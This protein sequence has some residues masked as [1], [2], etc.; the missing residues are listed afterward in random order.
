MAYSLMARLQQRFGE[1]VDR[2]TRREFLRQSLVAGTAMLLSGGRVLAEPA[3]PAGKS[4]IVIGAG[5]AGLAA[6]YELGSVGYDVTVIEARNRIGG[7]VVTFD[8]FVPG[9]FVEGGGELIGRNHPVWIAY[10]KKFGL[11]FIEIPDTADTMP[12]VLDGKLLPEK[13]ASRL[14]DEMGRLSRMMDRDAEPVVA[15]RPWQ[16]PHARILDRRSVADWLNGRHASTLAKKG[17]ATQLV[18]NNGV[19]LDR[20]SYL[21]MIAAVKGGGGAKYWTDTEVF[22]CKGGNQQLAARLAAAIGPARI[23]LT[24]PATSIAIEHG[25]VAVTRADGRKIVADDAIL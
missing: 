17:L 21:G 4:V 9:R 12:I 18:A 8:D 3:N 1:P 25:K 6:T 24:Q 15:D 23:R 14:W 20:Q 2:S 7:R 10:A 11:E 13:E 19:A 22:H 16:T 5:F